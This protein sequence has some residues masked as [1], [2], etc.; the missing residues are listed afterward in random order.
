MSSTAVNHT[1]L[2]DIQDVNIYVYVALPCL[3]FCYT[4]ALLLCCSR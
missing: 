4:G 2:R 3:L 1:A